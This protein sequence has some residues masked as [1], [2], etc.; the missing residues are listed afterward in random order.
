MTVS[1]AGAFAYL[2]F[3][4]PSGATRG[5]VVVPSVPGN[6][7]ADGSFE[8]GGASPGDFVAAY[9][10]R[11]TDA[12]LVVGGKGAGKSTVLL[13]LVE[14]HGHEVMSGDKTVVR[15]RPDGSWWTVCRDPRIQWPDS[16][17]LGPDGWLY[18]TT[19]HIHQEWPFNGLR[20]ARTLPYGLFKV[21][22]KP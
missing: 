2:R 8:E 16:I 19:S 15:R 18:F 12:V 21:R 11:G 14:H 17:A 6:L 5:P 10:E 1:G 9:Q 7:L 20:S 13:E 22:P 4:R 3:L